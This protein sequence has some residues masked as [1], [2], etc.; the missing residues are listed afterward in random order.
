MR[1]T[2]NYAPASHNS[3]RTLRQIFT[4][5]AQGWRSRTTNSMRVKA[6]A[7]TLIELLVVIAI[8]AIL[9][10]MLL[11]ALKNARETAKSILC[12]NNMKQLHSSTLM[13]VGDFN[14]Y[15]PYS[16]ILPLPPQWYNLLAGMDGLS[17]SLGYEPYLYHKGYA[18][19][20]GNPYFCASNKAN[21]S[22]G[23]PAWT[24]Y[25]FNSNFTNPCIKLSRVTKSPI[26]LYIDSYDSTGWTWYTNHGSRYSNPWGQQY[27]IHSGD[28]QNL[29]YVDGAAT[30]VRTVPRAPD[31]GG[32]NTDSGELRHEWFWP[33]N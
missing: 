8:I 3:N 13:Y 19:K 4:S 20:E 1:R 18:K 25:A 10:A 31:G 15:M 21:S 32:V 14:E 16:A 12:V 28:R 30:S 11:P 33:F 5:E 2:K 29:V 22:S 26:M 6:T 24:N 9:A 17:H 7:F 27:P 23:S